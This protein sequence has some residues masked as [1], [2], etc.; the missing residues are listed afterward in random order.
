[1]SGTGVPRGVRLP[2]AMPFRP[3]EASGWAGAR[4]GSSSGLCDGGLQFS[5]PEMGRPAP[6]H[7][8]LRMR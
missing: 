1:M 7:E 8:V 3:L 2:A 4:R 5:L 6:L